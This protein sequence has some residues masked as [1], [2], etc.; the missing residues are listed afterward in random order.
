MWRRQRGGS[1]QTQASRYRT[2]FM[3]FTGNNDG[4]DEVSVLM[5]VLGTSLFSVQLCNIHDQISNSDTRCGEVLPWRL[6]SPTDCRLLII[7]FSTCFFYMKG[8]LMK[9]PLQSQAG[10]RQLHSSR[11]RIRCY[12]FGDGARTSDPAFNF[13]ECDIFIYCI[14]LH[15]VHMSK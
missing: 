2:T 5:I 15:V 14:W 3:G 1:P 7:L 6:M 11:S 10:T 9:V 8:S 13:S 12:W 4:D